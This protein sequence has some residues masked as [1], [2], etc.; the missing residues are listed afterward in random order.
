[1]K[2][3][4]WDEQDS[5]D[6]RVFGNDDWPDDEYESDEEDEYDGF[7]GHDRMEDDY[8]EDEYPPYEE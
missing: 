1:M 4:D 8:G 5:G 2:P 6:A 3:F 7:Y